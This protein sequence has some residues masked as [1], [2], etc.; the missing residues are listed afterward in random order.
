MTNSLLCLEGQAHHRLRSLAA[1][2]FTPR[3]VQ[4]L[5]DTM[6][7]V[8]NELVDRVADA[9][10]CD[11]VTDIARPYPV[12]IICALLGAP[13]GDWHRFSLWADDVFKAFSFAV[14]LAEVEPVVMRAWGELDGYVDDMVARRR[15]SLT[16]DLLS[17]LIRAE[18]D[19]NP[20]G[21]AAVRAPRPVGT[22]AAAARAGDARGRGDDAP[23][24]DR[25]RN[26]APGR[27]GRRT[28]GPT[29]PATSS[30][31]P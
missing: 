4:R 22:A 19:G 1:K 20:L 11:V 13:R 2:A 21:A 23:F 15:H 16:D 10:R 9:G 25:V 28:W 17:D 30:P 31:R 12:P 26:A 6:A 3:A 7:A 29:W 8:M 14:D 18:D 24:A 5:H 27:R